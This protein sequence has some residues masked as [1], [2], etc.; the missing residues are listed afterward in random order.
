VSTKQLAGSVSGT[1]IQ[2]VSGEWLESGYFE[3]MLQELVNEVPRGTVFLR[4]EDHPHALFEAMS[5]HF[6]D[7]NGAIFDR[8]LK[9]HSIHG[10][11]LR[12]SKNGLPLARGED[13]V[14]TLPPVKMAA[15]H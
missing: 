12:T 14:L 4:K 9:L 15:N 13:N 10:V 3:G 11:L 7:F 1:L 2:L 5:I 6:R 8:R